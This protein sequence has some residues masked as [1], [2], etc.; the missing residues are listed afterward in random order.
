M[1]CL[2]AFFYG[3]SVA[4]PNSSVLLQECHKTLLDN[5]PV[6]WAPGSGMPSSGAFGAGP[7]AACHATS[8]VQFLEGPRRAAPTEK[9]AG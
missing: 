1:P 2:G 3:D 7:A 6:N 9:I 5:Q 4:I 8:L